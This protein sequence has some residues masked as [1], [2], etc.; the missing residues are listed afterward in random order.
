MNSRG[1]IQNVDH[2]TTRLAFVEL[3]QPAGVAAQ[4]QL[5][6]LSERRP[7]TG[8]SDPCGFVASRKN[9]NLQFRAGVAP[10]FL[11]A[12]ACRVPA[13]EFVGFSEAAGFLR[14]AHSG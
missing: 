5:G 10:S 4:P 3:G 6:L 8:D 9:L 14:V 1:Q 11:T 7:G 13:R 2:I 12:R